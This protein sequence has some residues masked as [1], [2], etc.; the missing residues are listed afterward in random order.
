MNINEQQSEIEESSAETK[1]AATVEVQS[2]KGIQDTIAMLIKNVQ[3]IHKDFIEG[4]NLEILEGSG[5]F[6]ERFKFKMSSDEV[7]TEEKVSTIIADVMREDTDKGLY[8]RNG[9]P[10]TKAEA[11]E[12]IEKFKEKVKEYYRNN[13][14]PLLLQNKEEETEYQ[15]KSETASHAPQQKASPSEIP[16]VAKREIPDEKVAT[17]VILL[18]TLLIMASLTKFYSDEREKKRLEQANETHNWIILKEI[19]RSE[20][21]RQNLKEQNLTFDITL[22][23]NHKRALEIRVSA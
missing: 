2:V 7:L 6:E 3:L 19:K 13:I 15:P 23:E 14:A 4:E 12:L 22:L 21:Q 20:L 10:L 16:I 9:I 1:E 17:K 11:E 5:T 18:G 8:T